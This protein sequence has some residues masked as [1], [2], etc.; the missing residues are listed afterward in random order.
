MN[1]DGFA[2]LRGNGCLRVTPRK[3]AFGPDI[4]EIRVFVMEFNFKAA[5]RIQKVNRERPV[6]FGFFGEY[7]NF[8]FHFPVD[9]RLELFAAEPDFISTMGF[10]CFND[11][12]IL[13]VD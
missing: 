8:N 13:P 9:F 6:A 7:F 5:C 10:L 12:N 2:A 11:R 3:E 4:P 1:F